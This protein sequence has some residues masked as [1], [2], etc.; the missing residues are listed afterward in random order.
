MGA[1]FPPFRGGILRYADSIG[2]DAVVNG[3]K[4]LASRYGERFEPC[5]TLLEMQRRGEN[6][7]HGGA[8]T[9]R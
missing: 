5:D 9:Q 2:L 3:L 1:G 8:E 4:E 6:F 7:Y